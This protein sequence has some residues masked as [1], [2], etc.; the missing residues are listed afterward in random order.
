MASTLF[1]DATADL[2]GILLDEE[3]GGDHM[4]N[5]VPCKAMISCTL[6]K[7]LA[8]AGMDL[9]SIDGSSINVSATELGFVPVRGQQLVV[10]GKQ[11]L[12]VEKVIH[13]GDLLTI[14]VTNY[15][16]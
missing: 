5:G 6:S 16:G 8:K 2:C 9:T 3:F 12:E 14:L 11:N 7:A 1:D 10:D 15:T 13:V 4:I